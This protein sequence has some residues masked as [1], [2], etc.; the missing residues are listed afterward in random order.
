[1]QQVGIYEQLITQLIESRIDRERFYVG[2]RELNGNEASVWLSRFLSHILEYAIESVPASD[3]RLQQQISLSNQLLL[4]LKT[5]IQDKDFI[6]DNLLTSQGKILTA[7]Y[8]LENPVS[9][10]L[11][12]YINDIFPLTGLTQSELFCGSNAGLSLES[13]LKREIL[14]ADKIYWLVSFIKWAGIRIFRKELEAFT[15]S[16]REL[17]IITTSYMGATDAKAVEYLASLP[18]TEVR[19]SYNTKRERLHAKSYLFLRDTSYHTGYIGSSN[20]SHSAL[21]NGLEWNLKITSQE[22]PHIINKSLSTFETYWASNDFEQFNNDEISSEKLNRALRQQRGDYEQSS[23]HFFDITPFPHQNEILEQ[24]AVERSVHS[25]FRNLV[26]AATGTG[27]TLISAFDFARFHKTKPDAKFLFVAHREEILKQARAAYRGVL[28]NGAF[29]ELWVGGHTPEHYRQLFVSIQTLNNQLGQLNLTTDYYDYIVIDEVH[30]IAA[31]SYRSVL[32]HFA[33]SILLGLTATPERHDGGDILADFG[34]VIAAEIRLPEA[35]NRR[36]LCPFQYFGIDDDTDLRTISWSRGRYDVSQL[37]NLYTHNQVRFDKILLSLQEI[38]TDL[39]KMKALAFCVSREHAQ[40]MVQ[41]LLLKGIKADVLTSDNSQERQ[42]K[43][44]A[45]RTGLINVLCVVDIFN[46]G[47][48]IPEVDTLLFL[49]PTESLTIFLQQLGRGLRL[50]EDKQCCTVLDFVGNSRPEYDFANKFRA[51]V[52][53][54]SR[55][56][57]EEIKQG[58]PHAPLGCRIELTKQTQEMVLTNIRQASLT[59]NRLVAMIR[60]FPQHSNLPLNLTNFLGQHPHIDLNELY[61]RGCWAEL[62]A[63]AQDQVKER[64]ENEAALKTIRNAIHNRILT[65]DDHAYLNFLKQLCQT[66]FVLSDISNRYAL[67]CH[68]DFW[69]KTGP[70]LGFNSISQS[71][72]NLDQLGVAGEL[73]DVLNWQIAQ[74]KH[75]QKLMGNLPDVTL[76]LHARYAREQ[77]L[78]AF[79][80]TTFERQ[81]PSREGLFV[82]QE[83]NIE[84]MFVTLDKNEKQFSPTTMYHD[85]AI[86]EHIFHWQ[87]QNSARPDRGRGKDYIQHREIGKRLFLFVREQTKDE[88]GRTMGFVNYGEVEY[89]SHIGSQ[90][91]SINWQLKTPMP[92]FMW[93]QAAKLAVG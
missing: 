7:L 58:F 78:A 56:I 34:G 91:M 20:L 45:I 66:S 57:S 73:L 93:Q 30:H 15:S 75:E 47:V 80:A 33:P 23:T 35:I 74:T 68:Y 42:Q 32:A 37:T 59:L 44:Q 5:Q 65:C 90:P 12:N 67:M 18:N 17:K 48:D 51:L 19:L 86:N 26:V 3:D 92:N 13:E 53:K 60:Q 40:Y 61:K 50:A 52:G 2:E 46:E 24:L 49:R 81:P 54:S 84:L 87:S 4:W 14:S 85:Y 71:L 41:K 28:R 25:R 72:T 77:I 1:M 82:I 6:E 21:T 63:K 88:Y 69:Q 70:E 11:K 29:G 16:G 8:D 64:T 89:L 36:H 10:D 79:G 55:A 76:R 39:G 83:Q 38:I 43:Q 22:I 27:K 31:S 9:A 62:V